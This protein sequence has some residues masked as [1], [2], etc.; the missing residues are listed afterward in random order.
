MVNTDHLSKSVLTSKKLRMLGEDCQ[1]ECDAVFAKN[2]K[3][4]DAEIKHTI[5][6]KDCESLDTPSY[7]IP[8]KEECTEICCNMY[9]ET[10]GSTDLHDNPYGTCVGRHCARRNRLRALLSGNKIDKKRILKPLEAQVD[11][12]KK[13]QSGA[14]G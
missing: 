3:N 13:I 14:T 6:T 5:C 12:R 11:L 2:F 10:C 4:A 9:E 1:Q 7:V 8:A